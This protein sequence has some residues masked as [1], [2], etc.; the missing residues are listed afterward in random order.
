MGGCIKNL[1]YKSNDKIKLSKSLAIFIAMNYNE[2]VEGNLKLNLF[3]HL[4]GEKKCTLIA[5]TYTFL[6]DFTEQQKTGS[7]S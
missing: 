6:F 5:H 2:K 1:L 3:P 7:R 4:L